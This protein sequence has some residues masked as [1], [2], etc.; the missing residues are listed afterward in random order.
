[1]NY[2]FFKDHRRLLIIGLVGIFTF[3]ALC[4]HLL[5]MFIRGIGDTISKVTSYQ[6]EGTSTTY[7]VPESAV[8]QGMTVEPAQLSGTMPQEQE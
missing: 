5:P 6:I 1:M 4:L 8:M 2:P 3:I 7:K